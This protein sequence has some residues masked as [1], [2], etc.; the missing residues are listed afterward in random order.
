[1][2]APDPPCAL[3]VHRAAAAEGTVEHQR[4]RRGAPGTRAARVPLDGAYATL[5]L[6]P[7]RRIG[8]RRVSRMRRPTCAG[9]R[10]VPAGPIY[11]R[12]SDKAIYRFLLEGRTDVFVGLADELADVF[13][14]AAVDAVAGD[15]VEGFNPSHDVC[16]FVIDGAV[17]LASRRSGRSIGNHDFVLDEP[18][19]ACP[20]ASHH[21]AT[22]LRLD[23]AALDRK[24]DAALHTRSCGR[25]CMRRWS[26]SAAAPSPSNACGRRPRR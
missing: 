23:A 1:M 18:P 24:I 20:E 22:W 7:D 16:R 26:A 10:R 11:G 2:A 9:A 4:N 12:Y 3:R 19:D 8:R 13:V 6:L 5:L 25:K 15:A 21:T 14:S 17:V